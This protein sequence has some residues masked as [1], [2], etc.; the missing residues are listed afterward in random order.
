V[1]VVAF[2][3][4]IQT[5]YAAADLVVARAGAMTLAEIAAWGLPSI[6]V[7]LPTAAADHQTA[8]AN[9]MA[10]AGA[11]V[12]VPQVEATGQR[13]ASEVASLV[14]DPA[15]MARLAAGALAR[16]R[17]EALRGIALRMLSLVE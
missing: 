6:L 5:A 2:L 1:S 17:P 13:L 9:A 7:P 16:G 10:K 12:C 11:A 8:N 3:D 15:A 4:P 14:G